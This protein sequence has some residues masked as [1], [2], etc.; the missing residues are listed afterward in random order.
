MAP[1]TS[2]SPRLGKLGRSAIFSAW[3]DTLATDLCK[4][5]GFHGKFGFDMCGSHQLLVSSHLRER[6]TMLLCATLSALSSLFLCCWPL[7]L[8]VWHSLGGVCWVVWPSTIWSPLLE[9]ALCRMTRYNQCAGLGSSIPWRC[10]NE[11]LLG[12][13]ND[14]L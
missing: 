1:F 3:Q 12:M 7:R 4:R 5:K 6:N 14:V 11:R 2:L 8:A 13:R 10:D 9:L